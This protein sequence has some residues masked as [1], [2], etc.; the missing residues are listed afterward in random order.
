MQIPFG[1]LDWFS[2][3]VHVP[4]RFHNRHRKTGHIRVSPHET[5]SMAHEKPLACAGVPGKD[6]TG[7]QVTPLSSKMVARRRQCAS[8]SNS[9]PSLIW[10]AAVYRLI[11]Q[12]M[13]YTLRELHCERPLV[14]ARKHLAHNFARTERSPTGPS[15]SLSTY[16]WTRPSWLQQTTQLLCC[17]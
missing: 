10:S 2:K 1:Q 5:H 6:Y 3:T 15:R 13:I 7:A 11:K 17:T 12:R 16:V 8:W 14:K 9:V 4:N